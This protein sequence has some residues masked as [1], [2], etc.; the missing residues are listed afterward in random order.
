MLLPHNLNPNIHP[1]P[2]LLAGDCD[3]V[4]AQIDL[5]QIA[6]EDSLELR[7]DYGSGKFSLVQ[8]LDLIGV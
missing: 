8:G 6:T 2:N 7:L 1:K 5:S 4:A 3:V